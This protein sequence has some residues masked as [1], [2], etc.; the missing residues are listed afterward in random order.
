[1]CSSDLTG[2]GSFFAGYPT[3]VWQLA[4]PV[5]L[6]VDARLGIQA[7]QFGFTV[8]WATNRAVVIE[9]A[10]NLVNASWLPVSTNPL[11]G[12]TA[13]FSDSRWRNY[14]TRIYRVRSWP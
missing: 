7:N 10:T 8:S 3:A 13:Y 4:N 11:T 9:A 14:P 12:G 1:V 2:W 6:T 5:I